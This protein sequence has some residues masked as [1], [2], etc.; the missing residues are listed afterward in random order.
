M[1]A[2]VWLLCP[3]RCT[4]RAL[5]PLCCTLTPTTERACARGGGGAAHAHLRGRPP[6]TPV[7]W[8]RHRGHGI[9]SASWPRCYLRDTAVSRTTA[10]PTR[11]GCPGGPA[12]HACAWPCRCTLTHAPG[13]RGTAPD[14]PLARVDRAPCAGR[15]WVRSLW[16]CASPRRCAP[17]AGGCAR[18]CVWFA[19]AARGHPGVATSTGIHALVHVGAHLT[20]TCACKEAFGWV[21]A[22]VV[23]SGEISGKPSFLGAWRPSL[24]GSSGGG[25]LPRG[26]ATGEG[27]E[28]RCTPLKADLPPR[29]QP[30]HPHPLP[31]PFALSSIGFPWVIPGAWGPRFSAGPHVQ[32]AKPQLP[33]AIPSQ[34]HLV[35][36]SFIPSCPRAL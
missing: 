26:G 34:V 20:C 35:H 29:G 15:A 31:A 5:W 1:G 11:E 27:R 33:L 22:Y 6:E 19:H 24:S 28:E 21:H 13:R 4:P 14:L 18:A 17:G 25:V 36:H 3:P 2:P 23:P 32:A 12:G 10:R 7:P 30:P 9:A 8:R 16:T